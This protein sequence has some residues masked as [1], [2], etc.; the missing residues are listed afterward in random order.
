MPRA[1]VGYSAENVGLS[2]S[3]G[4]GQAATGSSRLTGTAWSGISRRVFQ[5]STAYSFKVLG[6]P[7]TSCSPPSSNSM[8][9][10][11]TSTD[12]A[13]NHYLA[14]VRVFAHPRTDMD[15]HPADVISQQF[16]LAGVKASSKLDAER[17]REPA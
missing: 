13:R 16:H 7:L 11:A 4:R 10:P 5:A 12:D 1:R 17:L 9:D 3:G 2:N 8:R 15:A 6:T 14:R